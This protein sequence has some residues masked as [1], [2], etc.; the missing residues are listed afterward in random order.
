MSLT[1][2]ARSLV[3]QPSQRS[4][5]RVQAVAGDAFP[6]ALS[7]FPPCSALRH[8]PPLPRRLGHRLSWFLM[9]TH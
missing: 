6:A 5:R 4:A 3:R 7:P 2:V 8:S 1:N 9:Q